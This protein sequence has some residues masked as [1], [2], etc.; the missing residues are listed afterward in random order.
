MGRQGTDKDTLKKYQKIK[1]NARESKNFQ[2]M[3]KMDLRI[4][5]F[6]KKKKIR[7]ILEWK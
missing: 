7:S 5:D 3:A 6:Y 2:V 1:K 4:K